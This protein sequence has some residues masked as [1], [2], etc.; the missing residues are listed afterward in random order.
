M[1]AA[2]G[3]LGGQIVS[4]L[5]ADPASDV[6]AVCRRQPD[7][8]P[9]PV[10]VAIADYEN[11]ASLCEALRGVDTL[12][13]ISSDGETHRLLHHH[14]NVVRAVADC[15]VRH[16]V[17]LSS[18]DADLA[19]PFCYAVTNRQ[20]ELMLEAA[21]CAVSLAR[22]SIYTEFF[23]GWLIGARASGEI[24]LPAGA[25]RISLVSRDDVGRAMAVLARS[26]PSGR[27]HDLTGPESLDLDA[28]AAVAAEEYGRSVRYVD[29]TPAEYL[30]EL[31]AEGE[32]AWWMY[33]YSSMFASVR[34]QR[35]ARTSDEVATLTGREPTSLAEKLRT[36][37]LR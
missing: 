16:V 11:A 7:E 32:D 15:G 31:A 20:T 14:H 1:T 17:A 37:P 26:G 5:A 19:S 30:A 21:G 4:L 23:M 24:R 9:T 22:A 8:L 18:L 6:V 36:P 34:E 2:T 33:A 12:V 35:W 25:G 13:F 3:R 29:L 28:I 27:H 10:T